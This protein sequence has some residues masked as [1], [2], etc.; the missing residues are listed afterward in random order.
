MLFANFP[1]FSNYLLF[2]FSKFSAFLRD[3]L[4]P[5]LSPAAKWVLW[6]H[7]IGLI[8]CNA[9]EKC[10]KTPFCKRMVH[11][12]HRS[13]LYICKGEIKHTKT[14]TVFSSFRGTPLKQKEKYHGTK[15]F[16]TVITLSHIRFDTFDSRFTKKVYLRLCRIKSICRQQI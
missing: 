3:N 11:S 15:I 7:D 16:K 1:H 2:A 6:V 5:E 4:P 9:S 10:I 8:F 13:I 12:S 14:R